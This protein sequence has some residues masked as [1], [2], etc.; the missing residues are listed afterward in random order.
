LGKGKDRS[1]VEMSAVLGREGRLSRKEE[2]TNKVA[3]RKID[4][5]KFSV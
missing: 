4:I 5:E 1:W 2:Q 3:G